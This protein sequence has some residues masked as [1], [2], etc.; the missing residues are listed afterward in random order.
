MEGEPILSR[1]IHQ[2]IHT[3]MHDYFCF[4]FRNASIHYYD[5]CCYYYYSYSAVVSFSVIFLLISPR[6]TK[7]I[8]NGPFIIYRMLAVKI[9]HGALILFQRIFSNYKDPISLSCILVD[10]GG[11]RGAEEEHIWRDY[12]SEGVAKKVQ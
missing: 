10:A 3:H 7:D 1:E 11:C 2:Y 5:D 8:L 9:L 4:Y 12:Y 6:G